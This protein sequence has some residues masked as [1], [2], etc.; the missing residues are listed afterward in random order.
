MDNKD[1][2]DCGRKI[3][4]LVNDAVENSD[5]QKKKKSENFSTFFKQLL[6]K[7]FNK[8]KTDFWRF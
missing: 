7:V 2:Y 5:F 8:K 4:D 1:W 6:N 3:G